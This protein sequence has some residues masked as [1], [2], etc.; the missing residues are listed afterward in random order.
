ME[1]L[2][3][4]QQEEMQPKQNDQEEEGAVSQENHEHLTGQDNAEESPKDKQTTVQDETQ[5]VP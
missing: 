5:Y 3:A 4:V 1:L 2:P